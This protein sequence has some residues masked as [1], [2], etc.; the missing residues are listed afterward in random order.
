MVDGQPRFGK[1]CFA[2]IFNCDKKGIKRFVAILAPIVWVAM[3]GIRTL[4]QTW[5]DRIYSKKE[6]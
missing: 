4:R 3:S 1:V 6:L 2:R 5:C